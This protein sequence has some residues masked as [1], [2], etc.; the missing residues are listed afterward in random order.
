LVELAPLGI[1]VQVQDEAR[2]VELPAGFVDTARARGIGNEPRPLPGWEPMAG[3]RERVWWVAQ[4]AGMPETDWPVVLYELEE[5]GIETP[6]WSAATQAKE[7][8]RRD[9][10]QWVGRYQPLYKLG[11]GLAEGGER[12]WILPGP[13]TEAEQVAAAAG[14]NARSRQERVTVS[15]L[16]FPGTRLDGV[17]RLARAAGGK[18]INEDSGEP[19]LTLEVP[20]AALR[21]LARHE[22]VRLID[23]AAFPSLNQLRPGH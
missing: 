21:A 7:L 10:I 9:G 8:A 14:T 15:V 23:A 3:D 6:G 11:V 12:C 19:F 1:H 20:R 2:F 22:G 17:K 4:A 13:R 16:L 5:Q 18:V